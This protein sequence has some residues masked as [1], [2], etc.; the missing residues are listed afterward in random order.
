MCPNRARLHAH[1]PRA[2]ILGS[3]SKACARQDLRVLV[4]R[5]AAENHGRDRLDA[6]SHP[7]SERAGDR[8]GRSQARRRFASSRR[9]INR[10]TI[11]ASTR[12]SG[13]S[14]GSRANAPVHGKS[15]CRPAWSCTARAAAG[16]AN[17]REDFDRAVNAKSLCFGRPYYAPRERGSVTGRLLVAARHHRRPCSISS[18]N[19]A[20]IT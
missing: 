8:S 10:A 11:W 18:Q 16:S 9:S 19:R 3:S 14:N 4:H 17:Q 7:S 12:W 13:C 15:C 20:H 1:R 6:A 2:H 5:A